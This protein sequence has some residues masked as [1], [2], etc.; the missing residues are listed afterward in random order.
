MTVLDVTPDE[1]PD[2]D[3]VNCGGEGIPQTPAHRILA[4]ERSNKACP[5]CW[6]GEREYEVTHVDKAD[7]WDAIVKKSR[8]IASLRSAL[9]DAQAVGFAAGV[10]A[11]AKAGSDAAIQV[12]LRQNPELSPLRQ[13]LIKQAIANPIRA[14]TPPDAT[15]AAARVLLDDMDKS[16][17]DHP[18]AVA[19]WGKANEAMGRDAGAWRALMT[20]LL[21]IAGDTP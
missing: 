3:C 11:A 4:D 10:E 6:A 15:A 8:E 19:R 17:V 2:P 7:A 14:L 13:Q 12:A 18:D 20:G 21:A 9:A 16:A 1:C 5:K